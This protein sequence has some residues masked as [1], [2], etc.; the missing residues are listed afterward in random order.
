MIAMSRFGARASRLAATAMPAAPPPTITTRACI[1]YF[2]R[3]LPAVGDSAH[4]ALEVEARPG[5]ALR[6]SGS[7][8]APACES[9]HIVAE[10]I[11][12]RQY[13]STGLRSSSINAPNAAPCSSLTLPDS[14][15]RYRT[16]SPRLRSALDLG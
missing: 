7:G 4:D 15:G 1:R 3:R 6:I 8:I 9:A 2:D 13:A 12:V 10:R 5:G 11:P 14:A 16:S